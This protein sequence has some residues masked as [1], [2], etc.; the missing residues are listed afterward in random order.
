M[1]NKKI[2]LQV[3]SFIVGVLAAFGL[4]KSLNFTITPKPLVLPLKITVKNSFEAV[5]ASKTAEK[6]E[7]KGEDKNTSVEKTPENNFPIKT[8]F[9]ASEEER[10]SKDTPKMEEIPQENPENIEILEN[11][12]PTLDQPSLGSNISLN[13]PEELPKIGESPVPPM[14]GSRPTLDF[15]ELSKVETPY[16]DILVLGI[17][18]NEFG[19]VEDVIIVVPSA[20]P[21][22][23]VGFALGYRSAKWTQL[24]PPLMPGEK[25][26]LEVRINQKDLKETKPGNLP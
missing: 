2:K 26:W 7:E 11:N 12:L 14:P 23:D 22:E 9:V 16:E 18:V 3:F 8:D 25:R 17:L 6:V 4:H 19:S 10:I 13:Q 21:L 5:P 1:K 24:D 20:H 15:F